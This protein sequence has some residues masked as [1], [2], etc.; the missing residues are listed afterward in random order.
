M[1]DHPPEA[2]RERGLLSAVLTIVLSYFPASVVDF[3]STN[4]M[5]VRMC[6]LSESRLLF[7]A[8]SA[9]GFTVS[10]MDRVILIQYRT[11]ILFTY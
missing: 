4:T 5:H 2:F 1:L 3:M 10:I 6:A 7:D 11:M 9:R 8:I